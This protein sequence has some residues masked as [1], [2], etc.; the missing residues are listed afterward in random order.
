M[1]FCSGRSS[2]THDLNTKFWLAIHFEKR[3]NLSL[4]DNTVL[5]NMQIYVTIKYNSAL[6]SVFLHPPLP[7]YSQKVL[8]CTVNC[9]VSGTTASA[10]PTST[11]SLQRNHRNTH[12]TTL[13]LI[14]I[15]ESALRTFS[16]SCQCA[17]T[18]STTMA[19]S[20]KT[21]STNM[22]SWTVSPIRRR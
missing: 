14:N 11:T 21:W 2:S 9:L 16:E 7:Y 6:T 1:H 10:W 15:W 22:A 3:N 17:L 12:R 8:K 4:I 19:S 5:V 13:Q 20:P 18:I